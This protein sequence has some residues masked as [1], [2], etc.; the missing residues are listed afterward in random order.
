MEVPG[1]LAMHISVVIC[2]HNRASSLRVTLETVRKMAVPSEIEWELLIVDNNS[3]DHSREEIEAFASRT[4]LNI[5]YIWEPRIGKSYAL[6]R[7]ISEARGE[8][9][10][11]TDDDVL[12]SPEWLRELID[13]F[14]HFN[15]AGVGGRCI[16]AWGE[17]A[18]PDW[19][20]TTGPYRLSLSSGA[21]LEFDFGD[22]AKQLFLPPWGLNMAFKRSA[23]EKYGMF[24][25]DLGPSGSGRVLGEDTEFGRRLLRGGEKI[26]Y[27]PKVIVH[28][29]VHPQR[30]TKSYFLGFYL[31][32]GRA[33]VREGGWPAD[34]VLFFGIPRYMLRA[35]F[36]KSASWLFALGAKKRFYHKANLYLLVGQMIE[37]HASHSRNRGS[38][39]LEGTS[40]LTVDSP[41]RRD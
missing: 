23:F 41:L 7:G 31:N 4:N 9:I 24:R 11:F 40:G 5:R 18:R 29:P 25:T 3:N 19:L 16:P 28:H 17:L 36:E 6:N 15:C 8:I 13:A 32:Y 30:I 34:A 21:V 12:L 35:L 1:A 38:V 39:G 37:A 33:V 22:E 10:A 27:A 2:T 20:V 26:V 14:H